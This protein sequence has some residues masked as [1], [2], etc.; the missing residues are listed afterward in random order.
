MIHVL[1]QFSDQDQVENQCLSISA[2]TL[3]HTDFKNKHIIDKIVEYLGQSLGGDTLAATYLT[4]FL[5]FKDKSP[6]LSLSLTQLK[7]TDCLLRCLNSLLPKVLIVP[8]EIDLLNTLQFTSSINSSDEMIVGSILVSNSTLIVY[9]ETKL[10]EGLLK[11][12]GCM[13]L[14]S[15]KQIIED[16]SLAIKSEFSDISIKLESKILTLSD[17]KSIFGSELNLK[18]ISCSNQ[19]QVVPPCE[20]S[21]NEMRY[22]ISKQRERSESRYSLSDDMDEVIYKQDDNNHFSKR[23]SRLNF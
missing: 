6:P 10:G 18:C 15:L 16:G 7:E 21:L 19:P 1:C 12:Q 4:Y 5:L 14:N 23:L 9:D 17:G 3:D 8:L 13:N 11:E 20:E 22:F 2:L